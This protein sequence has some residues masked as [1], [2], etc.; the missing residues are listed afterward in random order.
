MDAQEHQDA[1]VFL[2]VLQAWARPIGSKSCTLGASPKMLE[3]S[4]KRE[5]LRVCRAAWVLGVTVRECREL[6]AGDRV[7]NGDTL[8]RMIEVFGWP[9]ASEA[10]GCRSQPGRTC[11]RMPA[12]FKARSHT[13]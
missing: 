4:R 5:G 12:A 7:P 2:K 3:R 8:E 1:A 13:K 6:E 9:K 11:S 10:P